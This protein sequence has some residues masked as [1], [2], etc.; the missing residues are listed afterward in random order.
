MKMGSDESDHSIQIAA[1]EQP[2]DTLPALDQRQDAPAKEA[3]VALE[4]ARAADSLTDG[5]GAPVP[6][7]ALIA[8]QQR[9]AAAI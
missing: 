6:E 1:S 9:A 4:L 3:E 2:G 8:A 5:V 7:G